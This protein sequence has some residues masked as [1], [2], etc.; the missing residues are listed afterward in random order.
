MLA[1]TSW[2]VPGFGDISAMNSYCETFTTEMQ[3]TGEA[4]D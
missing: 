3:G 2:D 1:G 4:T